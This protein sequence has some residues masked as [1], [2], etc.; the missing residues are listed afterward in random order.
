[1]TNSNNTAEVIAAEL[2]KHSN[3]G[4]LFPDVDYPH[5]QYNSIVEDIETVPVGD[6][7][8]HADAVRARYEDPTL[9][10]A[11]DLY[12]PPHQEYVRINGWAEQIWTR[13]YQHGLMIRDSEAVFRNCFGGD[14]KKDDVAVLYT[15]TGT[16][17]NRLLTTAVL[18]NRESLV[19]TDIS[20]AYEREGGSL[21][22]QT[23]SRV[24]TLRTHAGKLLPETL[25]AFLALRLKEF[26]ITQ[27]PKVVQVTNPGEDGSVY[28]PDE[29]RSL[30]Q[31]AHKYGL[32]FQIDGARL[33]HAAARLGCS[34]RALTT[35]VDVDMVAIGGSKCGMYKAEAAVFLPAF[36]AKCGTH[37]LYKNASTAWNELRSV[38]KR[39]GNL[40]GQSAGSALQFVRA[41]HDDFAI[42]LAKEANDI[43]DL[44]GNG[45]SKVP[46]C[47]LFR[48]VQSNVVLVDM[49]KQLFQEID[50]HYSQLMI[51]PDQGEVAQDRLV[52]R[53]IANYSSTEV[54][55]HKTIKV[56]EQLAA[57]LGY[58]R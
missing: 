6:I 53:F 3:V 55:A 14:P 24:H 56:V 23:G 36:F 46:Q 2:T 37:H 13:G 22:A 30:A 42:K 39:T 12:A 57:K 16:S 35:D 17:A 51:W 5:P 9:I 38:L 45:L 58:Q 7:L 29:I 11:I 10:W 31:I 43:A 50:Q 4:Q 15:P 8:S 32:L 19:T 48:P 40:V 27:K 34:L 18:S 28:T 1:M 25:E 41:L 33:F 26:V 49:P 21:E 54:Q 20:H 44:L 52:V 47:R